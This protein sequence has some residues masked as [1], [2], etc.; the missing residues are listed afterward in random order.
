MI[1][2]LIMAAAGASANS[3]PTFVGSAFAATTSASFSIAKPSGVTAGDLMIAFLQSANSS[4]WM[5]PGG[6]VGWTKILDQ[7]S[8][9]SMSVAYKIASSSEESSYSFTRSSSS[10]AASGF[11]VVYRGGVIDVIGAIGATADPIIAPSI[12][13]SAANSILLAMYASS[14]AS[15][16]AS[17]PPTGMTFLVG[18]SDA[19]VPSS[20]IFSQVVQAGSTGTRSAAGMGAAPCAG[21]LLSIKPA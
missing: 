2:D 18:D 14:S 1:F 13:V 21:V 16:A 7:G 6:K 10:L 20:V 8:S 9:P 11:I 4:T 12:S 19:Q 3:A 5:P 15:K 17:S